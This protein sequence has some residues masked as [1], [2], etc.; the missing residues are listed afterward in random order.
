MRLQLVAHFLRH[1][2]LL[3]CA[4]GLESDLLLFN[5]SVV[6]DSLQAHELQHATLPC[7]SPRT[8][9]ISLQSKELARV[10]SNT[11]VQSINSLVLSSLWSRSHIHT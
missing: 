10:F 5:L 3:I 2:F 8:G 11:T 1:Y 7:P 9:L 4:L 6:L